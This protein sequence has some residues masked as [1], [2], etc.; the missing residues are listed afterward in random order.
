M[1]RYTCAFCATPIPGNPLVVDD[2]HAI[3]RSCLLAGRL[4]EVLA[5]WREVEDGA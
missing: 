3:C 1:T 2:R 5:K 4:R